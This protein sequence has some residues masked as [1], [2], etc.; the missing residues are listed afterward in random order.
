MNI[1]YHLLGKYAH[2]MAFAE[3]A[4]RLKGDKAGRSR[5]LKVRK[6]G[7]TNAWR[8]RSWEDTRPGGIKT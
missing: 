2:E 8:L 5:D 4:E 6:R 3:K 1:E 7:V